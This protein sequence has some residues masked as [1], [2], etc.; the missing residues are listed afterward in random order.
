M[1]D[2]VNWHSGLCCSYVDIDQMIDSMQDI[3]VFL[4]S[5]LSSHTSDGSM[6]MSSSESSYNSDQ[7]SGNEDGRDASYV[8]YEESSDEVDF[9]ML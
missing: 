2:T 3:E 6:F 7:G 5:Q 4:P 8:I 9:L 1:H